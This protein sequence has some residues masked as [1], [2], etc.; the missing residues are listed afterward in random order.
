[1]TLK[2]A[3]ALKA[4]WLLAS[5]TISIFQCLPIYAFWDEEIKKTCVNLTH[6][7]I[8]NTVPNIVTD[9]VILGLP[10]PII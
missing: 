3:A 1:M 8:G 6:F 7:L 10:L 9:L 4:A 2:V 5:I